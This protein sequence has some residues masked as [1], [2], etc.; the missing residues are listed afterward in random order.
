M[1]KEKMKK[2]L[3]LWLIC[4]FF[5]ACT[6]VELCNEA[7]H[8]HS[9][10]LNVKL[11]FGDN[12]V[13]KPDIVQVI[14]SRIVNTW[15]YA[16]TMPTATND[17]SRET[18]GTPSAVEAIHLKGGEY[19]FFFVGLNESVEIE[20][21]ESY[22]NDYSYSMRDLSLVVKKVPKADIPELQGVDWVDFN[23]GQPFIAYKGPIFKDQQHDIS[24]YTDTEANISSVLLPIT[25]KVS[26][27]FKIKL[28]GDV[29]VTK[30]IAEL[31]GVVS[32]V[33]LFNNALDAERTGRIIFFPELK[34]TQSDILIYHGAFETLGVIGSK[35]QK[36]VTGPGIVQL[37]I[38]V[39]AEGKNKI[40]HGGINLKNAINEAGL[41]KTVKD[42][43][44][45][46]IVA[47]KP[48]GVLKVE[49]ELVINAQK[50]IEWEEEEGFDVWFDSQNIDVEA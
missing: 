16:F 9:A 48:E 38:Y 46:Y 28:E 33:E 13:R 3:S 31:S 7:E 42:G 6:Q 17:E 27:D 24:L 39:E 2:L 37:A 8:P 21:L 30:I 4:S 44:T 25:Q 20:K 23:P 45:E 12:E 26:I 35:S 36:N 47:A 18:A 32:R 29:R 19:T 5:T 49:K 11:G 1:K 14:A 50:I 10:I 15:R 40:F 41:T 22:I 43:N 34:S